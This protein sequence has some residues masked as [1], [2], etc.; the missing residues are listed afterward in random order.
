MTRFVELYKGAVNLRQFSISNNAELPMYKS[1]IVSTK[2]NR[3][4][5]QLMVQPIIAKEFQQEV[6]N[7]LAFLISSYN[8]SKVYETIAENTIQ[9]ETTQGLVDVF[10]NPYFEQFEY[11]EGFERYRNKYKQYVD[12]GLFKSKEVLPEAMI[13]F[14]DK[15]IQDNLKSFMNRVVPI[16]SNVSTQADVLLLPEVNVFFTWW[17]KTSASIIKHKVDIINS[18]ELNKDLRAVVTDLQ[19][20]IN[21]LKNIIDNT[22]NSTLKRAYVKYGDLILDSMKIFRITT[23]SGSIVPNHVEYI[24]SIVE[25]LSVFSDDEFYPTPEDEVKKRLEF[26]QTIVDELKKV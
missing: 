10:G 15:S 3:F 17:M 4:V 19:T 7:P 12:V 20:T 24:N 14:N 25:E 11:W 16:F 23:P 13:F 2:N 26:K 8:F 18:H 1:P 5:N 22:T 9:Q 6:N 21:D